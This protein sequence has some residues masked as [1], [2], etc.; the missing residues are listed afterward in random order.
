MSH[1]SRSQAPSR[2]VEGCHHAPEDRHE[3]TKGPTG[4][5]VRLLLRWLTGPAPLEGIA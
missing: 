1:S 4:F 2:S 5:G 3:W